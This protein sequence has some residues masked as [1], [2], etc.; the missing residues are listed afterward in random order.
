MS[1]KPYLESAG[2]LPGHF[3][4]T[5]LCPGFRGLPAPQAVRGFWNTVEMCALDTQS[6]NGKL[7]F[8]GKFA[9]RAEH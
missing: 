1:T 6:D 9:W 3:T 4:K 7:T 5:T 8:T 2:R